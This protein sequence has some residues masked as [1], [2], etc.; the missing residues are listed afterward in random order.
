M[1]GLTSCCVLGLSSFMA[2]VQKQDKKKPARRDGIWQ[3]YMEKYGAKVWR[4]EINT[5]DAEGRRTRHRG[6]GYATRDECKQVVDEIRRTARL[7]KLGIELPK[8]MARTTVKQT[9]AAYEKSREDKKQTRKPS[10]NPHARIFRKS[11][12]NKLHE[13]E[14]FV[15]ADTLVRDVGE[16]DLLAWVA[17]EKLAGLQLS[18]IS[19]SISTIRAC[20]HH[21]QRNRRDLA[22]YRVPPKPLKNSAADNQRTRILS[23]EEITA[24]SAVLA[25]DDERR[26]AFDFFRVAL[27]SAG[28]VDE[29]LGIRW[30]DMAGDRLRLFSSKTGKER[31]LAVPAVCAIIR[32]R[33]ADGLGDAT[34]A[35][36]C[37][38]HWLRRIFREASE[39][40]E[41]AYGQQKQS[42][43]TIHD[44][45]HTA[46][47]NLLAN[48]VDLATV[49]KEWADHYSIAQTSRY[50]HPTK[51]SQQLATEASDSI[52]A[53][54]TAGGSETST[55]PS[56]HATSATHATR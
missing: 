21:A 15:G 10:Q 50:L 56:T 46:L 37:R 13:W 55:S 14:E 26:D 42:G 24:L 34:H 20:L 11:S 47:T 16:D 30:Q 12:M 4:Y 32:Q 40:C 53:R 45:R 39:Q 35:F 51:R 54:A 5:F 22:D 29:L 6:S 36:T 3:E 41:I 48:N 33:Q 1:C 28:R 2:D 49:S 9:I 43:W 27:G 31:W 44:L 23:D 19:R 25:G 38:D 7:E 52:I 8:R 18:S 17:H